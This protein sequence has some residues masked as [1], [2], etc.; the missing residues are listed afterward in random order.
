VLKVA[1]KK[2][3]MDD[4]EFAEDDVWF[5]NQFRYNESQGLE[6]IDDGPQG[7]EI[8]VEDGPSSD[9]S[10]PDRPHEQNLPTEMPT[11][12]PTLEEAPMASQEQEEA[13]EELNQT[14]PD[15]ACKPR[16]KRNTFSYGKKMI[17]AGPDLFLD[18]LYADKIM[19][20]LVM[21]RYGVSKGV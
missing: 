5:G 1:V 19:D 4:E 14:D 16:A 17:L 7:D 13:I 6:L 3:K 8:A 21:I 18:V 15:L 10:P 2:A 12:R 20:P 9:G 11:A